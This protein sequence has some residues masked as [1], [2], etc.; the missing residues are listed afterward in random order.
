[1]CLDP[2]FFLEGPGPENLGEPAPSPFEEGPVGEEFGE[3]PDNRL[4][5][6]S[7]GTFPGWLAWLMLKGQNG[8]TR[9]SKQGCREE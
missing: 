7:L 8:D 2:G 1:M 5:R 3:L 4:W 6:V 9:K